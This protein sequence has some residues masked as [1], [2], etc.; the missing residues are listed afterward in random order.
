MI[1]T[2]LYS[3]KIYLVKTFPKCPKTV[4][5]AKVFTSE[6]FLLY[7][8]CTFTCTLCTLRTYQQRR[9]ENRGGLKKETELGSKA[10]KEEEALSN[11]GA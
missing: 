6:R 9:K 2:L 7:D 3:V 4:K 1:M 10:E 8:R 5:F 11:T